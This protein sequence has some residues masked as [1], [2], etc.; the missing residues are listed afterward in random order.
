MSVL[1]GETGAASTRAG[2]GVERLAALTS[3]RFVAAM[4]VVLHHLADFTP[5]A[6][7][8]AFA[9]RGGLAVDFFFILSGYILTHAHL[10]ELRA[11]TLRA[12]AFLWAR[13]ARIYPAHLVMLALFGVVVALGAALGQ[14]INAE[15]YGMRSLLTHLA[16]IN[17]WGVETSLTW[18]Y[19]AWSISAEWAAYL[20]FPAMAWAA[21]RLKHGLAGAALGALLACFLWLAPRYGWTQR[22]VDNA[23]PRIFFEF[24]MGMLARLVW[25]PRP[26]RLATPAA[27]A[28]AGAVAAGLW[29]GV[30]DAWLVAVFLLIVVAAGRLEGPLGAALSAPTFVRLGEESYALYLAHVFVFGMVFRLG[31]LAERLGAPGWL[32]PAAAVI[33]AVAA[34]RL[35]HSRVEAPANRWLRRH[36]PRWARA[37]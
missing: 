24:A 33:A 23:L 7:S 4:A 9:A 37:G 29:T 35:L 16:L 19:P 8:G 22:A 26:E 28:G 2:A 30:G 25:P 12:P 5:H 13:L 11:G 32:A 34:A 31:G 15:R 21:L 6:P 3:L 20:A 18:N 27:L 10:A 14:P 17:A 36:P 1:A